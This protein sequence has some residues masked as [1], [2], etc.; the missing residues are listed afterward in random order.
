MPLIVGSVVCL[1]FPVACGAVMADM[2]VY[3]INRGSCEHKV[4]MF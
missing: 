1:M 4:L 3:H 2:T